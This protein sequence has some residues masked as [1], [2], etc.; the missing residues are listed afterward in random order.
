MIGEKLREVRESKNLSIQ[1]ME[2]ET[3]IRALYIEAIEKGDYKTLPGEAYLRGFIKSYAN[4]LGL[5]GA[6]L[7]EEYKLEQGQAVPETSVD[8]QT[9]EETAVSEQSKV[10]KSV[11]PPVR[12][13]LH[14]YGIVGNS[15]K[16]TGSVKGIVVGVFLVCLVCLGLYA[17]FVSEEEAPPAVSSAVKAPETEPQSAELSRKEKSTDS[18]SVA[19]QAPVEP[20]IDIDLKLTGRCWLQVEVDDRVI[21][22]GTAQKGEAFNW[23]GKQRVKITA[24]NAGAVEFMENGKEAGKLGREGE[25]VTREFVKSTS[26]SEKK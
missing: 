3:S 14:G 20:E 24:G 2:K 21:Y 1:D 25:V 17:A 5:D 11:K 16:S 22:E 19:A 7:V 15:Q 26:I 18:V 12:T 6:A 23:K 8:E 13:K 9:A 4:S 10:E